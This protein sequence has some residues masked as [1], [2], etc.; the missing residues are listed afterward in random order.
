M[1]RCVRDLR[2]RRC[3][4]N[5]AMRDAVDEVR[6]CMEALGAVAAARCVFAIDGSGQLIATVGEEDMD[7]A[8]LAQ[9]LAAEMSAMGQGKRRD[10]VLSA[11]GYDFY[12]EEHDVNVHVRVVA[13]RLLIIVIYDSRSSMGRVALAAKRTAGSLEPL[14]RSHDGFVELPAEEPED[15]S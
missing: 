4:L 12:V 3:R 15:D 7:T 9:S 6:V 10:I 1:K 8:P 5:A 13:R 2:G 11:S 14:V